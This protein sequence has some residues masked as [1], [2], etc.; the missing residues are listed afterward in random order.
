[1]GAGAADR[2]RAVGF[3]PAFPAPHTAATWVVHQA[4]L[5]TI[6]YFQ[7]HQQV[8]IINTSARRITPDTITR[9][10]DTPFPPAPLS[11]TAALKEIFP[12]LRSLAE[13]ALAAN[14]PYLNATAEV[15]L[16]HPLLFLGLLKSTNDGS[17]ACSPLYSHL[18][19]DDLQPIRTELRSI[20]AAFPLIPRFTPGHNLNRRWMNL[21]EVLDE[22]DS[23]WDQCG[24]HRLYFSIL[25]L[26]FPRI[27]GYLRTRNPT[28]PPH[29]LPPP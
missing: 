26:A 12:S 11:T 5:P 29:L 14:V 22:I 8:N 28:L 20:K 17:A 9:F 3:P 19:G 21:T 7:A 18:T 23:E 2:D 24:H 10:S 4:L 25:Y 6:D 13:H 27:R 1:M 16:R 15:L